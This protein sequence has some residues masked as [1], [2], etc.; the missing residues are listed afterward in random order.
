L[1]GFYLTSVGGF[2]G[3]ADIDFF[4]NDVALVVSGTMLTTLKPILLLTQ[5]HYTPTTISSLQQPLA[6]LKAISLLA[7]I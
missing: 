6:T 7:K 3:Y 5:A 1:C 4:G 2:G